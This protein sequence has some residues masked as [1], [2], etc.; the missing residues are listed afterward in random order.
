MTVLFTLMVNPL[1][2]SCSP[3]VTSS[4]SAEFSANLLEA[5]LR[6]LLDAQ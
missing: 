4:F 6:H 5:F 2:E 3:L 1:I